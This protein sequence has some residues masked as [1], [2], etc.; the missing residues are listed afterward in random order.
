MAMVCW[1]SSPLTRGGR[2]AFFLRCRCGGLIP[3]YAGRTPQA[4]DRTR[5]RGA[6][7]RLRGA[8]R[9]R[10]NLAIFQRGSSPLTRG[11]RRN[12]ACCFWFFGLIPAYAGRTVVWGLRRR[13]WW[14]HPRLRGADHV[15]TWRFACCWGSS[16]LTRGGLIDSAR[17]AAERRL[18]PAYAGRTFLGC[19][20]MQDSRAH[21]RL[22]GADGG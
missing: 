14:A 8:D 10:K 2:R 4:P 13:R 6:H 15:A 5:D 16:P 22:R 18:I 19:F 21:P 7:P 1:G 17:D 12:Y 3:A 20:L 9:G 11:G